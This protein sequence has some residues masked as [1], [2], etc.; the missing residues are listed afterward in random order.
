MKDEEVWAWP[1][2]Q[3]LPGEAEEAGVF[4]DG[5]EGGG[6]EAFELDAE[7]VDDVD[8]GE[9]GVEVVGDADIVAARA[10]EGADVAGDQGGGADEGDL[11]AEFGEAVDIGAGDAGVGDVA[12]DG[13][14]DVFEE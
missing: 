11:G 10:G 4:A 9:D 13:D 8:G 3:A 6:G 1:L 2:P 12:D 14:V 5:G 7:H